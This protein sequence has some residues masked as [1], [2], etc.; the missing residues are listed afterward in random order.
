MF[1]PPYT[2]STLPAVANVLAPLGYY[3]PDAFYRQD[4]YSESM[5]V[6]TEVEYDLASKLTATLGARYTHEGKHGF[7]DRS[8]SVAYLA[9]PPLSANY[10]ADWNAVTPKA[11]LTFKPQQDLLFY[12]TA[13]RGFKSG[14]FDASTP[15]SVIGLQTPS[16]PTYVWNYEAG[17]KGTFLDNRL[18]VNL[19]VFRMDYKD[20]QVAIFDPLAVSFTFKNAGRARDDGLELEIRGKPLQWLTAGAAYTYQDGVYEDYVIQNTPPAPPTDNSGHQLVQT[21][22]NSLSLFADA[23][24]PMGVYGTFS[25][26]GS[27]LFRSK[28][29]FSD[30]NVIPDYIHDRTEIKGIVDLHATW[31]SEDDA[32]ELALWGRN[33]TDERYLTFSV[34]VSTLYR[35]ATDPLPNSIRLANWSAP[36]TYGVTLTRRF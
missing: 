10:D 21:P 24:W 22:K 32:W 18:L 29:H 1:G 16:N 13:T 25:M 20:L 33:V 2:S 23:Q 30:T 5:A 28:V 17:T 11:T 7:A 34:D 15:S 4:N 31:Q 9:G 8:N 26:G 3:H 27:V 36:P 12:V 6:F 35:P 19:A 14:A